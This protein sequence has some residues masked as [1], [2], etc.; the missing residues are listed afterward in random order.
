MEEFLT[1]F[2]RVR[3]HSTVG[4]V[5]DLSGPFEMFK[6]SGGELA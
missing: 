2:Y 6:I 4:K 5:K 3:I 1:S